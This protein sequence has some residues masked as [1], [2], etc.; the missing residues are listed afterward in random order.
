MSSKKEL[1]KIISAL[2]YALKPNPNFNIW[3]TLTL[4]GPPLN[5]FLTLFGK[6]N[7]HPFL[8]NLLSIVSVLIITWIWIKYAK[9]VTQFRHKTFPFWEELS[10]LKKQAKELSPVEI[11]QRLNVILERYET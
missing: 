10:L 5:L 1:I 11:E 7:Q 3:F 9:E 2:M 6:E 8:L 4:L